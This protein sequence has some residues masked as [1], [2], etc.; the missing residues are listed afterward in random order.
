MGYGFEKLADKHRNPVID[1]FNYYIENG[2]AAYPESKVGYDFFDMFLYMTRGYPAIAVKS[3]SGD[4]VGF[5]FLR[6]YHPMEAFKRTAEISYFILPEHTGKGIGKAILAYFVEEAKKL[7]IDSILADI[8]SLNQSSINFHSKNGFREC[9]RL[10][11][12]GRKFGK[13]FDVVWMQK[14]V[15]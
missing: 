12:V 2:F 1:I 8:S 11:K 14:T 5:A 9:G 6:A 15:C 13:D 7:G 10:K 4:I 3:D